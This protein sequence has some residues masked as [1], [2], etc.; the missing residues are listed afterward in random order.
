MSTDSL[1]A[2][3]K[4]IIARLWLAMSMVGFPKYIRNT[5]QINN[6]RTGNFLYSNLQSNINI[7]LLI[8]WSETRQCPDNTVI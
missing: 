3:E 6:R 1:M 2:Y 8:Q 7:I 4:I 5:G